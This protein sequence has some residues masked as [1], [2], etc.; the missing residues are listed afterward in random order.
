MV[1]KKSV[2][3]IVPSFPLSDQP[4]R[5]VP[6]HLKDSHYPAAKKAG[7]GADYKYPH[8]YEGGLVAQEYLP[9]SPK[10]YYAPKDTGHEKNVRRYLQKLQTLLDRSKTFENLATERTEDD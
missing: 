1:P 9:G 5:P 8:D 3:G 4:T 7:F 10:E 6:P 2:P